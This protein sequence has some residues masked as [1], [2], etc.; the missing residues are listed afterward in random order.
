MPFFLFLPTHSAGSEGAAST[1]SKPPNATN[2][3]RLK[4]CR[5][6]LIGETASAGSTIDE[7]GCNFCTLARTGAVRAVVTSSRGERSAA[8]PSI[9]RQ[10]IDD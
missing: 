4:G 3:S 5:S 2:G 10:R 6:T 8:W 1:L 7:N 9:E